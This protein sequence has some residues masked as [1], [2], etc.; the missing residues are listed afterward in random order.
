[1]Q[2]GTEHAR[3]QAEARYGLMLDE[4]DFYA[5]ACDIILTVAGDAL[6]AWLL[7]RQ[8]NGRE[9]WIVC[10]PHGPVV[11][12]VWHPLNAMIVT[13]LPIHWRQPK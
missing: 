7:S 12:V 3:I 8:P 11:P 10:V 1:M 9:I 4:H 6:R 13:V 5:M 2:H